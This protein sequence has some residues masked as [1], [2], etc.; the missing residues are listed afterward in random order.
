MNTTVGLSLFF[1]GLVLTLPADASLP[2]SVSAP[3]LAQTSV[4]KATKKAKESKKKKD[5]PK[6]GKDVQDTCDF[7]STLAGLTY[8]PTT[9]T[10]KTIVHSYHLSLNNE[11]RFR[12]TT[13]PLH[14]HPHLSPHEL[15]L[16]AREQPLYK[17]LHPTIR[18]WVERAYR[19]NPDH[20]MYLGYVPDGAESIAKPCYLLYKSE[21]LQKNGT[22]GC[23]IFFGLSK[24]ECKLLIPN[25]VEDA[26]THTKEPAVNPHT[27]QPWICLSP[28]E[29][30]KVESLN[31]PLSDD[32]KLFLQDVQD[33]LNENFHYFYGMAYVRPVEQGISNEQLFAKQIPEKCLLFGEQAKK[34]CQGQVT[35]QQQRL[36]SVLGHPIY[37]YKNLPRPWADMSS[38]CETGDLTSL[39]REWEYI[40]YLNPCFGQ[41]GWYFNALENTLDKENLFIRFSNSYSLHGQCCVSSFPYMLKMLRSL[42]E[43]RGG[44]TDTESANTTALSMSLYYLYKRTELYCNT[45]MLHFFTHIAHFTIRG[46]AGFS[47]SK[48]IPLHYKRMSDEIALPGVPG[49]GQQPRARKNKDE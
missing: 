3:F 36:Y 27:G 8:S 16:H 1:A 34:L 47:T 23:S 17:H 37:S 15:H 20:L 28:K 24:F 45:I 30:K 14:L 21:L 32:D 4:K 48:D 35:P 42:C 2:L 11:G 7:P 13:R 40:Y 49:T 9:K 18:A 29:Q 39:G 22:S 43:E 6:K 33:I 26:W 41:T 25:K 38:H 31:S 46:Y 19:E 44:N 12:S 5:K 10:H